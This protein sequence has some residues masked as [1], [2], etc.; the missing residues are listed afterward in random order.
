MDKND[1]RIALLID[2]EN[3]SHK[4]IDKI[5]NE[6]VIFGRPTYKKIYG[7]FVTPDPKS[8]N[9]KP[10]LDAWNEVVK[11]E[12]TLTQMQ[13]MS[14]TTGKNSSDSALIIDAMDILYSGNVEGICIVSSDSDFTG[15]AM[16]IAES[17][18]EVIGMGEE[19]T[20]ESLVT[21]CSK[22]VYLDDEPK[23]ELK[24]AKSK[25]DKTNSK[26]VKLTP[27]PNKIIDTIE[28]AI[29]NSEPD[30]DGW[31]RDS[32]VGEVLK[33]RHPEFDSRKYGPTQNKLSVFLNSLDEFEV[34]EVKKDNGRNPGSS[35]FYIRVKN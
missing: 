6:V 19:K 5:L 27:V 30:D 24:A 25:T 14:Y 23:K 35:I 22:F 17:G 7:D 15:L 18:I 26:K 34:K 9:K 4:Y 8:K 28:T 16:K 32:I 29:E 3:I 12:Y 31:V 10:R 33:R 21:A 2:A 20:P 1:K 11:K 13:Q